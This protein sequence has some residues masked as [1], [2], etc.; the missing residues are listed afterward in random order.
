VVYV[1][2]LATKPKF[3]ACQQKADPKGKLQ[4]TW[5]NLLG[6][7]FTFGSKSLKSVTL[8][9]FLTLNEVN[10]STG[11]VFTISFVLVGSPTSIM[12]VAS[13]KE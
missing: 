4:R 12:T 7:T 1:A 13:V 3:T 5:L 6:G 2:Q 8:A 11:L 10:R 9:A